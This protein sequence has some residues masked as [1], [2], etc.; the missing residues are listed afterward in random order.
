LS[1]TT[2]PG[3]LVTTAP[4]LTVTVT[5]YVVSEA[6]QVAAVTIEIVGSGFTVTVALPLN[7]AVQLVLVFASLTRFTVLVDV[8]EACSVALPVPS[9]VIVL[10]APPSIL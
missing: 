5:V 6:S 2:T 10:V 9:S 3:P 1:V 8:F 7:A 4:G